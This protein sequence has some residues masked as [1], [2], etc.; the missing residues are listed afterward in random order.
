M[1][2]TL[3]SEP[4]SA[5]EF[6]KS[7]ANKPPSKTDGERSKPA[8]Y[9]EAT[10]ITSVL[11]LQSHA[12]NEAVTAM[13]QRK[14]AS[15]LAPTTTAGGE[16]EGNEPGITAS[17]KPEFV[18]A[19]SNTAKHYVRIL[20]EQREGVEL[21]GKDVAAGNSS[22]VVEILKICAMAALA[23]AT[24]GIG[25]LVVTGLY[26]ESAEVGARVM[27]EL[28]KSMTAHTL[29]GFVDKGLDYVK[30]H[31]LSSIEAFVHVQVNALNETADSLEDNFDL[32]KSK[33]YLAA[34][35]K[36]PAKA[37]AD[38]NKF[39][40]AL[41]A[42]QKLASHTQY[43]ESLRQWWV[44]QARHQ[45]GTFKP[46]SGSEKPG[47]DLSKATG[48]RGSGSML[49]VI[50]VVAKAASS[51]T[52]PL[53]IEWVEMDTDIDLTPPL[54]TKPL[55]QLGLP[56][57]V[58]FFVPGFGSDWYTA[59]VSRNEGGSMFISTDPPYGRPFLVRWLSQRFA[60]PA[61]AQMS[62]GGSPGVAEMHHEMFSPGISEG[63]AFKAARVLAEE[64]IGS[65]S[66]DQL[67]RRK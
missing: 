15:G 22:A 38:L 33:D 10:D 32:L 29:E 34:F 6:A 63:H 53:Q 54:R 25:E 61:G 62:T 37:V 52:A 7:R 21:L 27:A 8:G 42:Q 12:G 4:G 20:R 36:N 26:E 30:E 58:L 45:M 23:A 66:I 9:P 65:R 41:T 13:L 40:D 2:T 28:T 48:V 19:L 5:P 55:S 60:A 59:V 56:Y 11:A 46:E 16:K 57:S 49:D 18:M 14:A 1:G 39:R 31:R 51:P 24:D 64:E 47:T 50:K 44:Y 17:T 35:D 43:T 3:R 67:N